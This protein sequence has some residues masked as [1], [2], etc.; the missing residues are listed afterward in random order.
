MTRIILLG[1]GAMGLALDLAAR[2]HDCFVVAKYDAD[3]KLDA[4]NVPDFDVAID[5][6]VPS[7]VLN[8]AKAVNSLGKGLV[9]GT[10]GWTEQF[11]SVK[12]LATKNNTGILYGS[13]F[14]IGVQLFLKMVRHGASLFDAEPSYDAAV[15]EWHHTRKLDSPSGTAL[16]TA[17]I[18][19]EELRRKNR[20]ETETQ[21]QGI[22]PASL[23]VTS[24]RTGNIVGTHQVQ[25]NGPFDSIEI[26]HTAASRDGFVQGALKSAVWLDGKT[27]LYDFQDVV[28]DV[29]RGTK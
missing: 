11:D 4:G 21:H 8:N 25:F 20:I 1:Y 10:T 28:L 14:S 3:E 6:S 15:Q 18:L 7:A 29:L 16:S 24:A 12:D 22:D 27:G 23:H 2:N 5:F 17:S 26:K 13:N 19:L 9:I